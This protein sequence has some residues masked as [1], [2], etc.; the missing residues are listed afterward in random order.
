MSSHAANSEVTTL[1]AEHTP[2]AKRACR[3]MDCSW[4]TPAPCF[5]GDRDEGLEQLTVTRDAPAL[6]SLLPRLLTATDTQTGIDRPHRHVVEARR[7]A[8]LTMLIISA[9][10]VKNLRS[11]LGSGRKTDDRFDNHVSVGGV[12]T[13]RRRLRP[14]VRHTDTTASPRHLVRACGALSAHRIAVLN[15]LCPHP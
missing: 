13:G 12:R 2:T 4:Y 1:R 10:Q 5:V 7:T 3:G 8:E 14:L 6:T 15:H 9:P 11:R